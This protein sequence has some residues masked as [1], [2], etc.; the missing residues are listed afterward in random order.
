MNI[1]LCVSN[2]VIPITVFVIVIF[3]SLKHI[4]LYEAFLEGAKEGLRT[5]VGVL[6]TLIGLMVAVE[7]LKSGGLL[8]ILT[9]L[10]RPLEEGFGLPAELVP[11]TLVRLVSS[12]AAIGFL[13]DIFADFG[14]DSFL[15]RVASVMMCCTETVFYT[16]SL[17]FLSV[18]ITKTRHTL[19]C[20][21]IA[22]FS[23][24]LAALF[25]VSHVFGK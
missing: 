22:N 13:T 12:S 19:F 14:P 25:L 8:E 10:L 18:K 11:L 1:L 5:V 23:G 15:G 24:V 16:M 2:F 7:V 21:L 9:A 20:A 17:Y 3:G 4:N 6:P